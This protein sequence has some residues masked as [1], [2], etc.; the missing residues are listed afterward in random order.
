M[1]GRT[2]CPKNRPLIATD[3]EEMRLC[4]PVRKADDPLMR[5]VL[6]RHPLPGD[7]TMAF[8]HVDLRVSNFGQARRLYD[9]LLPAMGYTALNED[10]DSCGY[11]R[12]GETGAEPFLWVVEEQGHRPNGTRIA[13]AAPGRAEVDRWAAVARDAGAA[14]F[15]PPALTREYGPHYYAAFFQDADGNKM[16]ICCQTS[17]MIGSP[18]RHTNQASGTRLAYGRPGIN[19]DDATDTCPIAQ[20]NRRCGQLCHEALALRR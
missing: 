15:E 13:F 1:K 18:V 11:H 6:T 14:A 2:M 20:R 12:P 16:E 7:I 8:D 17:G 19:R 4:V 5:A 9:A 10:A 3:F